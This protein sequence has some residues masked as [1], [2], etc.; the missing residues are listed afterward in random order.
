LGGLS[1]LGAILEQ[2]VEPFSSHTAGSGSAAGRRRRRRTLRVRFASPLVSA[3]FIAKKFSDG[4][5]RESV[6][7]HSAPMFCVQYSN[8][9]WSIVHAY[10][11]LNAQTVP[12][13]TPIPRKDVIIHRM[14]GAKKLSS[15]DLVDGYYQVLMELADIS[16]T[17][18]STPSGMRWEWLVMSQDLTNAPATFIRLVTHLFRPLRAFAQTNFDGIYVHTKPEPGRDLD[19]LHEEHLRQ[20]LEC[21]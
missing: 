11:K 5:V 3:V 13:Q 4:L 14:S 8:A 17:A 16:K 10:N 2:I 21:L 1:N 19:S 15:L 6:S 12:A 18:V 20:V 7:P 9:K